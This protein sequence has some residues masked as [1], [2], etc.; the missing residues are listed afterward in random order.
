LQA[1][2]TAGE[3]G[4]RVP[5]GPRCGLSEPLN[6]FCGKTVALPENIQE[7]C[8]IVWFYTRRVD[9]PGFHGFLLS[10]VIPHC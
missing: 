10:E 8:D 3:N 2:L 9:F 6:F 4:T 7:A 1:L 5:N